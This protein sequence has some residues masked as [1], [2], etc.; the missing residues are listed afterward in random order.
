M[1]VFDLTTIQNHTSCVT[2]VQKYQGQWL[3]KQKSQPS[4]A[5]TSIP[6]LHPPRPVMDDL[7][8]SDSDDDWVTQKKGAASGIEEKGVKQKEKKSE[9]VATSRKRSRDLEGS[10]EVVNATEMQASASDTP[11]TV[12]SFQLSNAEELQ[13]IIVSVLQSEEVHHKKGGC[14][15][16]KQKKLAKEVVQCYIS[17]IAKQLYP[18]ID[19]AVQHSNKKLKNENG[20]IILVSS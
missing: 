8:G 13:D 2:E 12:S 20:E 1:L 19:L 16:M 14:I 10:S 18:A 9:G 15:S 5:T 3:N 17:R 7:S 6:R 4:T 11:C